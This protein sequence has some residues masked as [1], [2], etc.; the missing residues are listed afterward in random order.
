MIVTNIQNLRDPFILEEGGV[1]YAYGTA[2][3]ANDWDNTIWGCYVNSSGD[4]RG[5]WHMTEQPVYE[6]P[7]HAVKQRWAPEVHKYR[8]SFYMLASYYSAETGHRGSSVLRSDSPTGPFVE[9]SD[10]HIT[11][12]HQD[13]IDATLY[14]DPD[15]QP[16][17]VYVHEWTSTE[18]RIGR[19]DAARLSEDL[20]RLISEPVEL[21]RAD[22]PRWAVAGVTDGCFLHRMDNGHLL[23]L[24][25][26]FDADGYCIAIAHSED[27][28]VDG[29]WTQEAAP[30]FKRGSVDGHDG[31]HGMVFTGTDGQLYLCIH[32]P[33]TPCA[34]TG[35][36][37]VLI[38]LR[39]KGNTLVC[40]FSD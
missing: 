39:E 31:G 27:G 13:S 11:P 12:H 34:E 16:W 20:T 17:L 25:S 30:L 24:W 10:G 19:M 6:L 36:R 40:D 22:A 18:D 7:A 4:L 37:T 3:T 23:M 5:P 33:N 32:S 1:Y 26:N 14:V 29:K 2:V 35:E 15:G 38:K 8:G 28:R 9:I 21:F